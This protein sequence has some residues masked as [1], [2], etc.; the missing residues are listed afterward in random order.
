MSCV[1]LS[2][3]GCVRIVA[4]SQRRSAG[5]PMREWTDLGMNFSA[6]GFLASSDTYCPSEQLQFYGESASFSLKK[7]R[8]LFVQVEHD[9]AMEFLLPLETYRLFFG[10]G[11]AILCSVSFRNELKFSDVIGLLTLVVLV[12]L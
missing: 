8:S 12:I 5:V 2:D 10:G 9:V 3:F 11:G 6:G 1:T 4:V 7:K